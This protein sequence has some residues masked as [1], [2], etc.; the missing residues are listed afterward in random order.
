[1]KTNLN[2]GC[3]RRLIPSDDT[4]KWINVDFSITADLKHDLREILPFDMNSIDYILASHL[5]E[6]FSP[7]EWAKVKKDW[8]RVL[9]QGG[10]LEVRVPDLEYACREFLAGKKYFG[11]VSAHAMIYG[12]QEVEGQ[13][14][15][16]GF[17]KQRLQEDLEQ[18]G[19][20]IKFCDNVPPV[21][22]Q[23]ICIAEKI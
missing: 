22:W 21:L 16:Q 11:M 9:K 2:L 8:Y 10:R 17:D 12:S 4:T 7:Y 23:I 14:H 19:F 6:H 20:K 15:H 3:G 5:A 1:M 18:E 13:M